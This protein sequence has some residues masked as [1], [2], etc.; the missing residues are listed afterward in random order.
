MPKHRIFRI[1][2]LP[3]DIGRVFLSVLIPFY[4]IRKIYLG[5]SEKAK[6]L[7]GGAILAANHASFSDPL[8]LE[9]AFWKRRVHFVVGEAVMENKARAFF[10]R[11]AGCIKLDRNATDLKAMKQCVQ[12][13][14]EGFLLEMFPQGGI[15]QEDA[16]FK[17]GIIFLAVQ[18]DVPVLPM[19][20]VRRK[21]WWQRYL[22]VIG[23]PFDW[24]VHCDKKRPG[25]KDMEQLARLLEEEYDKCRTW[26]SKQN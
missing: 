8:V 24:K 16:A 23:E 12:V 6:H 1:D 22:L 3:M 4:R 26:I 21:K 20:I 13:L 14:K 7:Q 2:K 11:A 15:A 18:A 25:I 10:M 17:S 5:D 9:T 19:Y